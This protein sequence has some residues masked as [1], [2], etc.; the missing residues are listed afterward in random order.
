MHVGL[1]QFTT[2]AERSIADTTE[3]RV[4]PFTPILPTS[5]AETAACASKHQQRNA[6]TTHVQANI[7]KETHVQRMC[8]QTSTK[9][10]ETFYLSLFGIRQ[11]WLCLLRFPDVGWEPAH[12]PNV[13]TMPTQ[14]EQVAYNRLQ[15]H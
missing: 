13:L 2:L 1:F 7:N 8:K 5:S 10:L 11:N 4:V 3:S 15:V 6:C 14:S 12:F 9:E